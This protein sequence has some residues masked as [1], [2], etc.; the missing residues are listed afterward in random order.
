MKTNKAILLIFIVLAILSISSC[1]H[2]GVAP[3]L[4]G[5]VIGAAVTDT[6]IHERHDNYRHRSRC[7]EYV[8]GEW[9]HDRYG[10]YWHEFRHPIEVEVPCR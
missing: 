7:Y 9:R 3:F 1:R 8:E 4:F 6:I 10:K 2:S 5:A